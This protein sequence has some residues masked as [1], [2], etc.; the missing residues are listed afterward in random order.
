MTRFAPWLLAVAVFVTA[1]PTLAQQSTDPDPLR[2]WRPAN[3]RSQEDLEAALQALPSTE[4]LAAFHDLLSSEPHRAG[5]PGDLRVV[6]RLR[7][8]FERMGLEVEAQQLLLYL[9]KPVAAEVEIVAPESV[10]LPLIEEALEADR[11][12]DHPDLDF[13]WNAYS[14]SGEV[15]GEVVYVN[16]G[17]LADFERLDELGVDLTGRI[18]VARYGGNFRGYKAK[19]AEARGAAGLI[20]Y[21]DPEDSGYVRGLMY[22]EGG[23]ANPS[24]IQR[25]SILT[26]DYNGDPLTP[27]VPATADAERLD[28]AEVALPTIPVQPMSWSAASEI[29]RR[30]SGP[31]V[32][33]EWQ[34]GLPFNYRLT[35]GED[36]RV[37]L[38]VEQER[39]LVETYN[40][41][42]R[43]PGRLFPDETVIVG[44]HHD[45]W[46]FGA[47]DPNAGSIVVLETARAFAELA[48][49]GVRPA[50]SIV[51]AQWGA[52]EFGILGSV[53]WVEA[54]A[55]SLRRDAV[56]YVNLDGSAMGD[57]LW[58]S[59]APSLRPVIIDAARSVEHPTN[60]GTVFDEWMARAPDA[61][62]PGEPRIG[63]MG[64]GSDHVGFYCHLGV[65][66]LGVGGSG[67]S[68][69]S[70]H[71]NYETLAWYHQVV[72]ADYESA[73][74]LTRVVSVL[75]ARLANAD[76][77]PLD[78]AGTARDLPR[79]VEG[80]VGR[81]GASP[82]E[83][84][85]L[86][87]QA[88]RVE[89]RAAALADAAMQALA[90]DRLSDEDLFTLNRGLMALE[91]DWLDPRGLDG[92]PWFRN[93]F[94]S[95]DPD[96]GYAPAMLPALGVGLKTGQPV[97]GRSVQ[98]YS[99]VLRQ[100]DERLAR[101]EAVLGGSTQGGAF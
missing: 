41:T 46:S 96:S 1:G 92:R 73:R 48:R 42:A 52:E 35:G 14:G 30:M 82:G 2:F 77:L 93:L 44:G 28:P 72:G 67:R 8:A 12:S 99:R 60:E 20:I 9:P 62:R 81:A 76:L 40:V 75:T 51:F 94:A 85:E 59:A 26:L 53:E 95:T 6:E 4:R 3:Q 24:Y 80:L 90:A 100:V 43:L 36:L 39:S 29:L 78:P 16:R 97:L 17:T 65:P 63:D 87:V 22:P 45:A 18:A 98:T 47:A 54:H 38:R 91:R 69:V 7:T 68:G 79:H 23:W 21:T 50:R 49:R 88:A 57:R 5:S 84:D 13:G 86:L 89:S 31:V 19:F 58:A 10:I 70:Y 61:R 33:E 27:F 83:L 32:P 64:G 71:S 15:V 37:R 11:Y 66:S 34:G 55:A 56:A 101:M 74:M 25:G